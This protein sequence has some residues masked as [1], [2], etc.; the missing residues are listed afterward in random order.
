MSSFR[1]HFLPLSRVSSNRWELLTV[2][3]STPRTRV[4]TRTKKE[5]GERFMMAAS[6]Q[7][8]V[9][10]PASSLPGL[11]TL[12]KTGGPEEAELLI[13]KKLPGW[14]SE[15]CQELPSMS[16]HSP[17]KSGFVADA[18]VVGAV[19]GAVVVCFVVWAQPVKRTASASIDLFMMGRSSSS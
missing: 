9:K 19:V 17:R 18:A 16:N 10:K 11:S 14:A 2:T 6:R 15:S 5:S 4:S 1:K 3:I 12:G 13:M 8:V 7:T